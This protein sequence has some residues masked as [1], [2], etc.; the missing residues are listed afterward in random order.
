[1]T[2][3][4]V[5]EYRDALARGELLVQSCDACGALNMYPRYACPECQSEALGWTRASGRGLLHSYTVLRIG[6]PIGFEDEI[7]YALGV[8][9]LEE[10]VQLLARLCP[11]AD[12]EWS[13]YACDA[14]VEFTP[15]DAQAVARRPVAWFALADPG[16]ES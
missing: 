15:A 9:K 4:L 13:R 6:S 10:G 14:E 11:D 3:P 5:Q 2:P 1:M 7:P 8:I 16:V 12:G